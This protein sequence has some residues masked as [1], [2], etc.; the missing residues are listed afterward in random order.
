MGRLTRF[1]PATR[2]RTTPENWGPLA[3]KECL[4]PRSFLIRAAFYEGP[5][6]STPA[7]TLPKAASSGLILPGSTGCSIDV[8]NYHHSGAAIPPPPEVGGTLAGFSV[9]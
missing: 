9:V 5:F 3:T 1:H 7:S 4:W 2:S 6:P 8:L